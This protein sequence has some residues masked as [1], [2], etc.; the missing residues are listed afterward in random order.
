MSIQPNC[1]RYFFAK[2]QA[3][4]FMIVGA[5]FKE[6]RVKEI[7]PCRKQETRY[8]VISVTASL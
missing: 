4:E 1:H 7:E 5:T 2:K 3:M 8:V 6:F